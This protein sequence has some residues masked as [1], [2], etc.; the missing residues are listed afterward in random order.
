MSPGPPAAPI[1]CLAAPLGARLLQVVKRV[2]DI[3]QTVHVVPEQREGSNES[4]HS[5][6]MRVSTV[7]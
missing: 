1:L 5:G 6:L 3:L 7:V 4:E 2:D